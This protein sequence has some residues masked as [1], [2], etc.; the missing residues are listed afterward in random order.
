MLV[1]LGAGFVP[2]RYR[3]GSSGVLIV[4]FHGAVDQK[5]REKP[6]LQPLFPQVFG[7]HQLAV[8]D[9]CLN[10]SDELKLCWYLG[11]EGLPLPGMLGEYF[12]SLAGHF[13]RIIFFGASGGGH[14]ALYHSAQLPGSLAF[15]V[16]PQTDLRQYDQE[17]IA[18]YIRYCWPDA[19]GIEDLPPWVSLDVGDVYAGNI[20][21]FVCLLN[22]AG[23]RQHVFDHTFP[24]LSRIPKAAQHRVLAHAD[25]YG[26]RGHAVSVPYK[27]C[28]PWIK[29]A[30][31]APNLQADTILKKYHQLKPAAPAAASGDSKSPVSISTAQVEAMRLAR[32]VAE[33]QLS[34]AS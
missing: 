14:A 11:A 8:S 33:H 9:A 34:G 3:A 7:A 1:D 31:Y 12:R 22:S 17:D 23:D 4:L 26:V 32:L 16:N 13:N 19:S 27:A 28:V 20:Q 25:Y 29:A 6:H 18:T 2:M 5:V 21:N 10:R 30:V 24:L 15:A